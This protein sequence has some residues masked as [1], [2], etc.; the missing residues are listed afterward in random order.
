[1]PTRQFVIIPRW[2]A[3]N[4]V[5]DCFLWIFQ[6]LIS[7]SLPNVTNLYSSNFAIPYLW[8]F[9]IPTF[10]T[11]FSFASRGL[12]AWKISLSNRWSLFSIFKLW[13]RYPGWNWDFLLRNREYLGERNS[14]FVEKWL[15]SELILIFILLLEILPF[16]WV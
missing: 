7:W 10:Q 4:S 8:I 6:I 11:L 5:I 14:C 16:L 9:D 3:V 1:M 2:F 12:F 15:L 13:L